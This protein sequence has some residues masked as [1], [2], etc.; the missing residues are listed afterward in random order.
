MVYAQAT[1]KWQYHYLCNAAIKSKP[2]NLLQHGS[3]FVQELDRNV[4]ENREQERMN[5]TVVILQFSCA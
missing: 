4:T 5:P 2:Y 1:I 3:R